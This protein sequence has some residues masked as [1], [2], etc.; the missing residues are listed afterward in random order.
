MGSCPLRPEPPKLACYATGPAFE[1]KPGKVQPIPL[2][3]RKESKAAILYKVGGL[4]AP[5]KMPGY[6]YSLP[7]DAC[8]IGSLLA[9]K[10]GS[11]CEGCYAN[12]G[13]YRFPNVQACLFDRLAC[14][15][16]PEWASNMVAAI[17]AV[18]PDDSESH[19]FRW[20][21]SGDLQS[22][23]HLA[24]IVEV[25]KRTPHVKHWLPTKERGFLARYLRESRESFPSNLCV[26]YSSHYI[27]QSAPGWL[28]VDKR[29]RWD[30]HYSWVYDPT[31]INPLCLEDV[32]SGAW[33]HLCQPTFDGKHGT[34]CDTYGCR[35]CWNK[36][37]RVVVYK[38][39]A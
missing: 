11:V 5:S 10:P 16:Q 22:A 3:P 15:A 17:N 14:V 8:V 29:T 34:G 7:C 4:S 20:H 24:S 30:G 32:E 35:E 26:R 18:Y 33:G 23:Q 38:R 28:T 12:R 21:D 36:E 31:T 9:K 39:H 2:P 27:N 19:Y 6:G 37:T 1:V 25:C 13:N